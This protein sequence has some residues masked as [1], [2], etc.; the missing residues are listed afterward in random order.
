MVIGTESLLKG[1]PRMQWTSIGQS[2][3]E[4]KISIPKRSHTYDASGSLKFG[5]CLW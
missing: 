1:V 5:L 3:G 4:Q 2:E